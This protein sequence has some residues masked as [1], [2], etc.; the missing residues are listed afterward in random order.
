VSVIE[1]F[2]LHQSGDPFFKPCHAQTFNF[3]KL[4]PTEGT[5]KQRL[6]VTIVMNFPSFL[7]TQRWPDHR[8]IDA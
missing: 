7:Y 1:R 3:D 5:S 8:E 6:I 2:T 4:L